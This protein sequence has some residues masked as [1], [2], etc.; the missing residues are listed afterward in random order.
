MRP[1]TGGDYAG[2]GS[3]SY[4]LEQRLEEWF[5]H[6]LGGQFHHFVLEAADPQRASRLTTGLGNV[7][8]AL[9]LRLV[10]HAFEAGGQILEVCLRSL[11]Y[12]DLVTSSTPT[13][14]LPLSS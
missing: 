2:G 12:L 4:V 5:E 9:G 13:A 8:S 10:T 14:L 6:T 7:Y 11:A 1:G 3:R